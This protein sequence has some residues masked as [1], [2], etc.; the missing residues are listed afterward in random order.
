VGH[1]LVT[2]AGVAA[3]LALACFS[4]CSLVTDLTGL[5]GGA[6][7]TS[8]AGVPVEAGDSSTQPTDA[9]TEA[10]LD[11]G[12]VYASAVLADRPVV[13]YRLDEPTGSSVVVDSIDGMARGQ[14]RAGAASGAIGLLGG[15][16]DT[17]TSFAPPDG[18]SASI[19][20][21][22][23]VRLELPTVTVE[24]WVRLTALPSDQF[25]F[26]T[27]G[28]EAPNEPYVLLAAPGVLSFYIGHPGAS[29][30]SRQATWTTTLAV[31]TTYHLVGTYDGSLVC[32]YVN[33]LRVASQAATGAA[34]GYDGTNGL[35]IGAIGPGYYA[36]QGTIDEVAIYSGALDA[37]RIKAHYLAGQ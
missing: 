25:S 26:V 14:L 36:T 24:A 20:F 7:G 27:Y 28:V 17:A 34:G 2:R 15:S 22:R 12:S 9:T 1:R 10:S 37:A 23:D 11:G 30:Q 21:N 3:L 6:D 5:S 8:E 19:L 13:Y 35:S 31:D 4:A 33:G 29:A 32:L 16:T 18:G